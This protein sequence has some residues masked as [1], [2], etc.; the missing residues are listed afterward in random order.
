MENSKGESTEGED[1]GGRRQMRELGEM[2]GREGEQRGMENEG[3]EGKRRE[4]I[5]RRQT[6]EREGT[7][8]Q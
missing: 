4:E 2:D 7:A 3:R 6:I 8:S 5:G 1:R